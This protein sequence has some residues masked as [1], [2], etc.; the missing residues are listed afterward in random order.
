MVIYFLAL[1]LIEFSTSS[2]SKLKKVTRETDRPVKTSDNE[3][4]NKWQRMTTGGKKSGTMSGT[5]S[6]NEWQPMT[7]SD[8]Q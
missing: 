3:R 8:N 2:D 1:E 7:T 5:T 4:Y 6:D